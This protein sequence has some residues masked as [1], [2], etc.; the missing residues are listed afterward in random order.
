[1]GCR[2]DS[3]LF[4]KF[5]FCV[6]RW[7]IFK[8]VFLTLRLPLLPSGSFF[9]A[10]D[11]TFFF[12]SIM[13][14]CVRGKIDEI[15]Y[16]EWLHPVESYLRRP[17]LLSQIPILTMGK[18]LHNFFIQEFPIESIDKCNRVGICYSHY[19]KFP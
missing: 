4:V 7:K 15:K 5:R 13:R 1:M 10:S 19:E 17:S 6:L 12:K 2:N 9:F 8:Q 18:K 16:L 11:Q 3:K 14:H